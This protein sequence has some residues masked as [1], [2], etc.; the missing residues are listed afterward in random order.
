MI[1]NV[2][3]N[4]GK[5]GIGHLIALDEYLNHQIVDTMATVQTSEHSWTEKIWTAIVHG[6]DEELGLTEAASIM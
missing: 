1:A 4:F 5:H 6:G 3:R 2:G